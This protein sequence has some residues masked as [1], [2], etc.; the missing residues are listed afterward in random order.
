MTQKKWR[1]IDR[2][3]RELVKKL[4]RSIGA[5]TIFESQ[6]N[7]SYDLKCNIK[8]RIVLVEIKDR[9]FPHSR[10][11]DVFCEEDKKTCNNRRIMN[12]EA[13]SCIIINVFTDKFICIANVN[14]KNGIVK[15]MLCPN[16][17]LCDD[18]SKDMIQKKILSL[19]QTMKF[20][21]SKNGKND[22][23]FE[24]IS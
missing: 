10:Y 3:S 12:G 9:N 13:Q 11:G 23:R 1:N 8:G 15:T 24:R 2:K 6:V 22:Y 19:P 14:D 4:L 20:K 18:R 17:T 21:Y 5:T 16:T 7:C